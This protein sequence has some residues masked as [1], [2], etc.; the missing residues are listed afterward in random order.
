[1]PKLDIVKIKRSGVII[2]DTKKEMLDYIG[3]S[4]FKKDKYGYQHYE[5]NISYANK[6]WLLKWR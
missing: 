4:S 2:F 6:K 1:M 3:K 5:L